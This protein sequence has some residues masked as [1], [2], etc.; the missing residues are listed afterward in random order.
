MGN[1]L[2]RNGLRAGIASALAIGAVVATAASSFALTETYGSQS[3]CQTSLKTGSAS[4]QAFAAHKIV[5]QYNQCARFTSNQRPS[6]SNIA[7]AKLYIS[8]PTTNPGGV[9]EEV[10]IKDGSFLT[11]GGGDQRYSFLIHH[12][13]LKIIGSGSDFEAHVDVLSDSSRGIYFCFGRTCTY[14]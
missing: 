5:V 9:V 10:T 4:I 1:K 12:K 3:S 2:K 7:Y 13:V 8:A 6:A 14:G 11:I